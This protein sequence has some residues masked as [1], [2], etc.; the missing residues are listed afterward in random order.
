MDSAYAVRRWAGCLAV[1]VAAA[2][3]TP[4]AAAQSPPD[5]P[6]PPVPP[7][8][9]PT[10]PAPP[11]PPGGPSE[12]P[13]FPTPPAPPGGPS[14]PPGWP[15]S[16]LP[17]GT[18]PGFPTPP[19]PPTGPTTPP[20]FPTEPVPPYPPGTPPGFPEPPD[21]PPGPPT[22]PSEPTDDPDSPDLRLEL[23]PAVPNPATFRVALHYRL[24][25]AA[26]VRVTLVDTR[27]REVAVVADEPAPAGEH[28]VEV[29]VDW[30]AAGL[31]VVRLRAGDAQQVQT[32][33]IVR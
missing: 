21:E 31:Y 23:A 26:R 29:D 16:P 3:A 14:A 18:P 9:P 22:F 28:Y 12:P 32:L 5:W 33:T 19:S 25:S 30:L 11:D 20:S 1:A 17:P 24:P 6:A 4:C 10:F 27:G 2:V 15:G 8:A 7:H 13:G